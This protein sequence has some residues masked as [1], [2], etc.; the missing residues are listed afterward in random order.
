MELRLPSERQCR[1]D[2]L[3]GGPEQAARQCS[4]QLRNSEDQP[5][6]RRRGRCLIRRKAPGLERL[7]ALAL[8][9][10]SPSVASAISVYDVIRLTQ[11][12]YADEQIIAL[13]DTTESVFELKAE[14]L[15][16]LKQLGVGEAVIRRMLQKASPEAS[17]EPEDREQTPRPEA[18]SP[19]ARS[20]LGERAHDRPHA[21]E[22]AVSADRPAPAGD[23][24]GPATGAAGLSR[25][26][27]SEEGAGG[28][29]HVA[30]ALA[31]V[32][33]L[34]LR[35]EGKYASIGVRAEDV[36]R[37]LTQARGLAEG[38]FRAAH[39]GVS[40]A[41]VFRDS[42]KRPELVVLSVSA[43]DAHAY[44]KRS[45]RLVT[46]DDLAAYWADLLNDYWDLFVRAKPPRRLVNLHEG[47]ALSTLYRIASEASGKGD[48]RLASAVQRLPQPAL[49]HLQRLAAAVPLEFGG[50]ASVEEGRKP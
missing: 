43:V 2:H 47:E 20:A 32:P 26:A 49:H 39:V 14:D 33:L 16:R 7:L 5:V 23:P 35:D 48:E 3:F 15:V 12:G 17:A 25:Y 36:V 31:G 37:R 11:N 34:I 24:L 8:V 28:H 13:I 10:V 19:S 40:D 27:V 30:V 42:S 38:E 22:E 9:L 45:G 4:A 41:V 46:P 21:H 29:T 44:Q 18:T 6:P 1:P 50:G